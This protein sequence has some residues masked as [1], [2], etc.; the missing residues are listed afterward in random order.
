MLVISFD[1]L[2]KTPL[3]RFLPADGQSDDDPGHLGLRHAYDRMMA[4]F[5]EPDSD[6]PLA[7]LLVR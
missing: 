4:D 1:L 3:W 2:A 7:E 6:L 5:G